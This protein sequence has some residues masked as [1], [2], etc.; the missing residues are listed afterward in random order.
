MKPCPSLALRLLWGHKRICLCMLAVFILCSMILSAVDMG[1]DSM[2][3]LCYASETDRVGT[4]HG[5]Y[6]DLTPIQQ[7]QIQG[8]S[9]FEAGFASVQAQGYIPGYATSVYAG[10]MD[11]AFWEI[12]R[13]KLLE[14]RPPERPVE[15]AVEEFLIRSLGLSLGD[16]LHM[17]TEA[18]ALEVQI[19]GVI[20]NYTGIWT[21]WDGIQDQTT[22]LPQVVTGGP[23]SG[24]IQAIVRFPGSY[25]DDHFSDSAGLAHDLEISKYMCNDAFMTS[26]AVSEIL[27][28]QI[29]RYI[30]LGCLAL[31]ALLLFYSAIQLY[32][33]L[34]FPQY[35]ILQRLGFTRRQC[36]IL[37]GLQM[38]MLTLADFA[39]SGLGAVFLGVAW[40][41]GALK[42]EAPLTMALL[43]A[44][45][46]ALQL[47]RLSRRLNPVEPPAPKRLK[48]Y[49]PMKS[50]PMMIALNNLRLQYGQF[51][52][53][54]S[55]MGLCVAVICYGVQYKSEMLRDPGAYPEFSLQA[56]N[57][58]SAVEIDG[59]FSLITGDSCIG[60]AQVDQIRALKG[61]QTGLGWPLTRE[62]ALRLNGKRTDVDYFLLSP[63]EYEHLREHCPA[64]WP[65]LQETGYDALCILLNPESGTQLGPAQ[66]EIMRYTGVKD[67]ADT[68]ALM[69]KPLALSQIACGERSIEFANSERTFSR[70]TLILSEAYARANDLFPGYQALNI[71][72]EDNAG[73]DALETQLR[74][75]LASVPNGS[76]NCDRREIE[77]YNQIAHWIER[78]SILGGVLLGLFGLTAQALCFCIRLLTH[79]VSLGVYQVLGLSGRDL[80]RALLMEDGAYLLCAA[81]L[82]LALLIA[83]CYIVNWNEYFLAYLPLWGLIAPVFMG[84]GLILQRILVSRLF[85]A[86]L[87][88]TIAYTE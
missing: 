69:V 3:Q 29:I 84:G 24:H 61:V 33:T 79:K 35:E 65:E 20:G 85:K 32:L 10:G 23:L 62:A 77:R 5:L 74:G 2:I 75:I 54:I 34:I 52:G 22:A 73:L 44:L 64:E 57:L 4:H 86:D 78:L 9:A 76:V 53:A 58:L 16:T 45:G 14:G 43:A 63:A 88:Q 47:M 50:V 1:V 19:T 28:L 72:T 70:P 30:V 36:L 7:A 25:T 87:G 55:A 60:W 17:D 31:A 51:I 42:W 46:C 71:H 82:G 38:G 18:G 48:S 83:F 12:G 80:R 27:N 81:L 67:G 68:G 21:T 39:V 11:P 56:P 49:R 6:Y 8:S 66:L 15:A 40:G 13:I 37:N 26:Q 59:Y 41:Q